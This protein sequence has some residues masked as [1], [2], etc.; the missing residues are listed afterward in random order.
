MIER[1]EEIAKIVPALES[2]KQGR[3]GLLHV[4]GGVGVG[5]TTLIKTAQTQWG[6]AFTWVWSR[7]DAKPRSS[8]YRDLMAL[9]QSLLGIHETDAV[10][11][12]RKKIGDASSGPGRLSVSQSPILFRLFGVESFV[13]STPLKMQEEF[14]AGLLQEDFKLSTLR[15]LRLE[16]V[17][18]SEM[19]VAEFCKRQPVVMVLD[20]ACGIDMPSLTFFEEI[21]TNSVNFP[22]LV[23][24]ISDDG[25]SAGL[26]HLLA[27]AEKDLRGD[28]KDVAIAGFG[29]DHS[30]TF[31]DTL[32]KG[33][34]LEDEIRKLVLEQANGN[35]L[36][37]AEMA[38][39]LRRTASAVFETHPSEIQLLDSLQA[40]ITARVGTLETIPKGL[41]KA[42]SVL[43]PEFPRSLLEATAT[44]TGNFRAA[45]TELTNREFLFP[46]SAG[47]D[48]LL[49]FR[50]P[51]VCRQVYGSL[52]PDQKA[53]IH[54][55]AA[56]A[57]ER[58]YPDKVAVLYEE[59]A[60]HYELSQESS[61][62][63]HYLKLAGDRAKALGAFVEAMRCYEK[64]T[65]ISQK[66]KKSQ[67][68]IKFLAGRGDLWEAS[69][70]YQRALQDWSQV[71]DLARDAENRVEEARADLRIGLLQ[72]R[73]GHLE[74]SFQSHEKAQELFREQKLRAGQAWNLCDLGMTHHVRGEYRRA[75]RFFRD[76]YKVFHEINTRDGMAW[77]LY[78]IGMAYRELR[79]FSQAL[80]SLE[81][82]QRIFRELRHRSGMASS[83]H[84]LSLCYRELQ[85]PM[86]ALDF[87]RTATQTFE[88]LELVSQLAWS[89][90]NISVIYR[91][92]GNREQGLVFAEKARAI[93]E[94][95]GLAD[96][97][98]WNL[99]GLG[100]NHFEM[101]HPGEAEKCFNDSIA[102]F[103]TL[104]NQQGLSWCHYGLGFVYRY[105]WKLDEAGKHFEES[106]AGSQK[107]DLR[108]RVGGNL[109]NLAAIHRY[110]AEYAQAIRMN[111]KALRLLSPLKMKDGVAWSL[112]QLGNVCKDQGRFLKS[113]QLHKEALKLHQDVLNK[114]GVA[115]GHNELGLAYYELDDPT[116][117]EESFKAAID[118]AR[119]IEEMPVIAEATV[120]LGA[121]SMDRGDLDAAEECFAQGHKLGADMGACRERARLF[122]FKGNSGRARE[123][124]K[125]AQ[126]LVEHRGLTFMRCGLINLE[127]E[128]DFFEGNLNKAKSAWQLSAQLSRRLGQK[129]YHIE[130]V[131]G[132]AQGEA[133]SGQ[134]DRKSILKTLAKI[135]RYL[136]TLSSRRLKVK[137]LMIQGLAQCGDDP[138]A[139]E[140]SYKQADRLLE[141]L[142]LPALEISLLQH[143]VAFYKTTQQEKETQAYQARLDEIFKKR[144]VD[145]AVKPPPELL[146]SA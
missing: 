7:A 25:S 143:M 74:E 60:Y 10:S 73:L 104:G 134:P 99:A 38:S 71:R 83:A 67:E 59:L 130:A 136:R 42:A 1:P 91:N 124:L 101:S 146:V 138:S 127:G 105:Q 102:I 86:V 119:E 128:I 135:H 61:V 103:K 48:P 29:E 20:G 77:C 144:F 126:N 145:P 51:I 5:K 125:E 36:Y 44:D 70:N 57:I 62:A 41:L 106:L 107:E 2:L 37:L 123:Y 47:D 114:K 3:G 39:F 58:L 115:W 85:L 92:M 117:A 46:V 110:K 21:L 6:Q 112:F 96:G 87:A 109:L 17:K 26:D 113:W 132:L 131:L 108:D 142:N 100:M 80:K 95:I 23:V 16:I 90:D 122:L 34:V 45:L 129:K 82:A 15:V 97:L 64:G 93:F 133:R 33:V 98:A 75:L 52:P 43:G 68:S 120:N 76:A 140:A 79:Q 116:R 118:V 81:D 94:R 141:T 53:R 72:R 84:D 12:I 18:A 9:I 55:R 27:R 35:P 28:F 63:L 88:E 19:L 24:L 139:A 14:A 8:P 89:Y 22:L 69:G 49:S 66:D 50:H 137:T 65:E 54:G 13:P 56:H 30:S 31:L 4:S 11:V 40:V 121:L 32:L 111:R 78:H